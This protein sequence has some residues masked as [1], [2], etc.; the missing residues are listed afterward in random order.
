MSYKTPDMLD[1][2][3]QVQIAYKTSQDAIICNLQYWA[4]RSAAIQSRDDIA[5]NRGL[6][7]MKEFFNEIWYPRIKTIVQAVR[8]HIKA[9]I[10]FHCCGNLHDVLPYLVELGVDAVT[11]VQA[12][13]NDIYAIKRAV[14]DKLCISG[15]MA[16]DGVLAF[17]TPQEVKEDT[18][19]HIDGLAYDGGY[20]CASSHSICDA[21]PPDNYFAMIETA[22]TY[23]VYM[24]Q[25]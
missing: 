3:K 19:A 17:G 15:N 2:G 8:T 22:Q 14:G 23:G 12:N 10:Q 6:M 25:K 5:D 11:P 16:I 21:I 4:G 7:V 18:K 1:A 24:K 9:P 13:C 20:I